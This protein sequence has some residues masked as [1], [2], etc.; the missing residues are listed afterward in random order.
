M[1]INELMNALIKEAQL[2]F[3]VAK[4]EGDAIF[5]YMLVEEAASKMKNISEYLGERI[6]KFFEVFS[7]KLKALQSATT[8]KCGCCSNINLLNL[9]GIFHYGK[10][11]INKIG[12]FTE[13]SG[14]DVIL[15]HRLLKNHLKEKRYL[16]ITEQA[17]NKLTLP[18]GSHV[19]KAKETDKDLGTIHFYVY[20]P[21][22]TNSHEVTAWKKFSTF[23]KMGIGILLVKTG[24]KK[25]GSFHNLP[26]P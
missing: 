3:Q 24:L 7:L 21:T 2:P 23:L 14:V 25:T 8:C 16:L 11:A 20:F 6:L 9:K 22:D 1:I 15:V 10:A 26:H 19:V 17:Y 13:L 18:A 12:D 4:L 5:L